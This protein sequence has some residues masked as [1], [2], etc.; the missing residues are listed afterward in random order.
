VIEKDSNCMVLAWPFT[1]LGLHKLRWNCNATVVVAGQI[2]VCV[3]KAGCIKTA[4]SI[5]FAVARCSAFIP[6]T[7][8]PFNIFHIVGVD[9]FANWYLFVC[10]IHAA[11]LRIKSCQNF[12]VYKKSPSPWHKRWG[13]GGEIDYSE[14]TLPYIKTVGSGWARMS[15]GLLR[16]C[17]K[18]LRHNKRWAVWGNRHWMSKRQIQPEAQFLHNQKV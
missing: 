15:K 14:Q 1:A 5:S 3:C 2:N 6:S 12:N 18:P 11:V 10:H 17:P 13:M 7:P 16:K 4:I 9:F 8:S